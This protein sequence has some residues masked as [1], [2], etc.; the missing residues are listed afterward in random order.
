M[1]P[2]TASYQPPLATPTLDSKGLLLVSPSSPSM[3][4]PTP[5]QILQVTSPTNIK[6]L[7]VGP[8]NNGSIPLI[9]TFKPSG[10]NSL[11]YVYNETLEFKRGHNL[12]TAE[13]IKMCYF[14][15]PDPA[16][17]SS[18]IPHIL[19]F[20]QADPP[21]VRVARGLND[22]VE[23]FG[24]GVSESSITSIIAVYCFPEV[25]RAV[26]VGRTSAADTAIVTNVKGIDDPEKRFMEFSSFLAPS[27]YKMHRYIAIKYDAISC[28][29]LQQILI[30][31]Y[32]GSNIA[33]ISNL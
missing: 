25:D 30:Y 14:E 5:T 24:L 12:R 3:P 1:Y 33:S 8:T 6:L 27:T 7:T 23:S 28:F 2:L 32:C 10:L 29:M 22:Q 13:T 26:I 20:Y 18:L 4:F 17:A 9:W 31:E 21:F 16:N 19:Y 11:S 15:Y